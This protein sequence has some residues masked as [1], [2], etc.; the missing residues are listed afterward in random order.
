MREKNDKNA[1]K[2]REHHPLEFVNCKVLAM[3][4]GRAPTTYG[5]DENID[6]FDKIGFIYRGPVRRYSFT[7]A[8]KLAYPDLSNY[9]IARLRVDINEKILEGRKR[10]KAEISRSEE[11]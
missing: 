6:L 1:V 11:E 4:L 5:K 9:E 7:D 2:D 8:A 10:D 3:L